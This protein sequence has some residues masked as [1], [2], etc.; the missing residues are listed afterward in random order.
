MVFKYHLVEMTS[1]IIAN[2]ISQKQPLIAIWCE[3][4][5]LSV[6]QREFSR[7]TS[8][9]PRFGPHALV[10]PSLASNLVERRNFVFLSSHHTTTTVHPCVSPQSTNHSNHNVGHV[11]YES[12]LKR[13]DQILEPLFDVK[14]GTSPPATR[15]V[16]AV[17][18]LGLRNVRN[19][20]ENDP[21]H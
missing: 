8:K 2:I 7:L 3:K 1:G 6:P 13:L 4:N 16:E 12:K 21:L 9:V 14:I 5:T 15:T 10:R 18:S 17:E 19:E 11:I 20:T